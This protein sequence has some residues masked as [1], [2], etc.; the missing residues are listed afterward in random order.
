[1][2]YTDEMLSCYDA[3]EM[4]RTAANSTNFPKHFSWNAARLHYCFGRLLTSV[5]LQYNYKPCTFAII[6]QFIHIKVK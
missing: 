3:C 2:L 5:Q 4:R 6:L 1:M